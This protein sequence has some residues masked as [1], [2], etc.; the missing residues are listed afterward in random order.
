M[1][2]NAADDMWFEVVIFPLFVYLTHLPLDNTAAIMAGDILKRLFLIKCQD[3]DLNCA[4][5][6]PRGLI[7]NKPALAP[8]RR[9]TIIGTNDG[10]FADACICYSVSIS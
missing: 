10:N 2:R 5:I 4:E 6:F 8:T 7:D 1:F 3:F 9:Q